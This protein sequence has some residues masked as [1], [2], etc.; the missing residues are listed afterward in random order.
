MAESE[1]KVRILYI[2]NLLLLCH[3]KYA[4]NNRRVFFVDAQ[5][6]FVGGVFLITVRSGISYEFPLPFFRHHCGTRLLRYILYVVFISE[7][8]VYG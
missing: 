8:V 6:I 7:T 4:P 2:Y 1:T 5:M 3:L